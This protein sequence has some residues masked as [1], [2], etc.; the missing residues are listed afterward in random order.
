MSVETKLY[1]FYCG[2]QSADWKTWNCTNCQKGYDYQ[3][4]AWRCDLEQKIDEAYFGDG[5]VS[6]GVARRMGYLENRERHNWPCGEL[7]EIM[8]TQEY[9]ERYLKPAPSR[10]APL[11]LRL[12]R[13]ASFAVKFWNPLVEA[14][15]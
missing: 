15:G 5:S 2:S 3:A 1:P 12:W 6:E 9:Y 8:P 4:E 10:L 11:W 13:A 7:V 14:G